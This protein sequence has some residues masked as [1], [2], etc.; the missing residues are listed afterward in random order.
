[1]RMLLLLC[2]LFF[3]FFE[4]SATHIIGGEMR[5]DYI[6][7][8]VAPNSKIYK[9]HLLLLKGDSP[10]GADLITQYIVG[11]F[12]NDNGQKVIGTAANNN[13]AAVED[14]SGKL[15]VPIIV[16]PCIQNPPTLL[17]KY[18][19]YSF[20]IELPDNISGY[21]VAFQTYSRQNSNN[22]VNNEG[23]TYSC[24]IPGLS[25]LPNPQTDHSP[26]YLLPISVICENSTFT[27]DF[28][29]TD[30]DNDSLVYHFCDAYNGGFAD[31][32]DYQNPVGPPYGSVTYVSPYNGSFPMGPLVTIN[33]HTG[34]I[35]GT[36]PAAGKYVICVCAEMYRNGVFI[37]IHRKDLIVAVNACTPLSAQSNF[38]PVTCD[39]FTVN[40]TQASLGNPDTYFWDFGDPA[41]GINN[42]SNLPNPPH[43]FTAAGIFNVKLRVS[44]AGQCADSITKPISVFPG[45]FPGFKITSSLCV[46]KPV[47]FEDT[48]KTNYGVIDSWRWDFGDLTTLADTSHLQNPSYT[49]NP[50]GTY[51]VEL[52]VTNSKGCEKTIT[53]PVF[54]N[55]NPAIAVS[56]HDST[57][58]SLDTLQLNGVGTGSFVWTPNINILNANTA[59]PLVF[60]TGPT[61]Y[62]AEITSAVGCKN[63]DSLTVTPINDLTNAI[64]GPLRICEE[65]TVA[66]IGSSNHSSNVSWQWS[67]PATVEMP[68]NS[69]TRVYPMVN[70]TYTLQTTWGSHCIVNKTHAVEVT[71]LARP[72]AG[73]DAFV[74]A[75][76]QT[77]TQL[78]ATGG[79]SYQWTPAT[80]LSDPNIP[81]PVATPATPT[82]Y[83]VAVGVNGCTKLKTDTV[84][85]NVGAL[86]AITPINDTLI[87]IPDTLQLVT[88]APAPSCGAPI[89]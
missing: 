49:Y 78:H 84:F 79:I 4:A 46:G 17:Y 37:G 1:M 40:F 16:S 5:Y 2:L 26:S 35:S 64:S 20:T 50:G 57:Y 38:T 23:A 12:N 45:F 18:K 43:T 63:I 77:S 88:G 25:V 39:G 19:T 21:T 89:T 74:C 55:D 29:A 48:S 33:P 80:G 42:T 69:S 73:P 83:V 15:D 41:S 61:K 85:V 54:I 44:I 87:C 3:I 59:N 47:M 58:C 75:G 11:V 82:Y 70:T 7:P 71:P 10:T 52:K 8:G 36:A 13:W 24:V 32:G 34:M 76:G 28:S 31:Q 22:V 86:P 6:G 14:F 56:P 81:D 53:V 30:A 66:L 72:N 62:Y 9:I 65:D 67:P 27:L 60:P 68:G 51:N